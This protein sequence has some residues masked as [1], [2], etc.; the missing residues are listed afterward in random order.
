MKNLYDDFGEW[1]KDHKTLIGDKEGNQTSASAS[2][3][4]MR[5]LDNAYSLT[6]RPMLTEPRSVYDES[7]SADV[8]KHYGADFLNIPFEDGQPVVWTWEEN[9]EKKSWS[10]QVQEAW[11]AS[12]ISSAEALLSNNLQFFKKIVQNGQHDLGPFSRTV[13]DGVK[14]DEV[15]Q[16]EISNLVG[17]PQ[18]PWFSCQTIGRFAELS[19]K[20]LKDLK[21]TYG[22]YFPCHM[23]RVA[24][25]R[26]WGAL[27]KLANAPTI[28]IGGGWNWVSP[29]TNRFGCGVLF[30][31]KNFG[32]QWTALSVALSS[33]DHTITAGQNNR[34][35][36]TA[37]WSVCGQATSEY[38][39]FVDNTVN[40]RL[41]YYHNCPIMTPMDSFRREF[42]A[43][44]N[45]P[46]QYN[47]N[48]DYPLTNPKFIYTWEIPPY[49]YEDRKLL[50]Y[51]TDKAHWGG[52]G[53]N[54][55]DRQNGQINNEAEF[56][57]YSFAAKPMRES[58]G[59][60]RGV[61]VWKPTDFCVPPIRLVGENGWALL[62][63]WQS[64]L[65][66]HAL[67]SRH[68]T[69][70]NA[71]TYASLSFTRPHYFKH[72]KFNLG[73]SA[74]VFQDGDAWKL[75]VSQSHSIERW[76]EED[77]GWSELSTLA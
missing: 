29:L 6:Y 7:L 47:I 62:Y 20:W 57:E 60:L 70:C 50:E 38:F 40:S 44:Q 48:L 19:A 74:S 31:L 55:L 36:E 58:D 26:A 5:S 11:Y 64:F 9:T 22:P 12:E 30:D 14:L 67:E 37:P 72:Y 16:G 1:L 75:S 28:T 15:C 76:S 34:Y 18:T 66:G 8:L 51:G 46:Q 25:E 23:N 21:I 45:Y 77:G 2:D 41:G 61:S 54:F 10:A 43:T 63:L 73:G 27:Y 13:I 42:G 24:Y 71:N 69:D 3:V 32:S 33:L 53:V 49:N 35:L 56:P 17:M 4:F 65:E 68:T 59:T 52:D 39:Y